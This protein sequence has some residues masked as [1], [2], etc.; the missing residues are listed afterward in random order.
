MSP[1]REK[2][3]SPQTRIA[4]ARGNRPAQHLLPIPEP[5]D[6]EAARALF[7]AQRRTAVRTVAVLSALLFGM[8]GAFALFPALG[9]IRP[10]GVPLSWLL[11]TVAIYPM[12]FGLALWHVRSAERIEDRAESAADRAGAAGT[13]ERGSGRRGGPGRGEHGRDPGRTGGPGRASGEDTGRTW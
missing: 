6:T 2:L 8:S 4:L 7:R 1:R 11:L 5:V 9:E 12:L 13:P 3:T 10:G